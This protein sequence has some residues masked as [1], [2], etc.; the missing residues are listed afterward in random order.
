M[1]DIAADS[2][3]TS[4]DIGTFATANKK[5]K[6]LNVSAGIRYDGRKFK[7]HDSYVDSSGNVLH[8]SN[9]SAYHRFTV[10]SSNLTECP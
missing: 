1:R 2:E 8:P 7:G 10:Y 9:P 6:K 5:I 3:Y 4:Y